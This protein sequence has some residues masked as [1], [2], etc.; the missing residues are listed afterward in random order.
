MEKSVKT[1]GVLFV[2]WFKVRLPILL[3]N[4]TIISTIIVLTQFP[5]FIW[6][7]FCLDIFLESLEL[8]QKYFTPISSSRHIEFAVAF[9]CKF[10]PVWSGLIQFP[11]HPLNNW[12]IIDVILCS[13]ALILLSKLYLLTKSYIFSQTRSSDF[14]HHLRFHQPLNLHHEIISFHANLL[15]WVAL[16]IMVHILPTI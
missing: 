13:A 3:Y 16:L 7:V 5:P 2:G 9:P 12:I 8:N 11:Y 1:T 10:D 6:R 14:W 4:A 15:M